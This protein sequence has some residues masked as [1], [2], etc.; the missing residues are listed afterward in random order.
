MAAEETNRPV[1]QENQE[2]E[3]QVDRE[4]IYIN[5][6]DSGVESVNGKSGVVT[7]T[8]EDVGALP[9]VPETLEPYAKKS[10]L[11]TVAFTGDYDD[12]ND[13]PQTFDQEDWELLW[14]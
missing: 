1:L 7:L 14:R 12:L 10:E 6:I 11:A 8:A 5:K 3:V 4:A 2:T 13:E 9:D